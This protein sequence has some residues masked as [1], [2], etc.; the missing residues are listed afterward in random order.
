MALDPTAREAN[1][2]DSIKKHFVDALEPNTTVI[3]D[4]GLATPENVSL[5]KWISIN[6]GQMN[7]STLS[8]GYLQIYVCTRKDNE[9][10]KLAQLR[11][12]VMGHLSDITQTDGM[13]RIDFYRSYQSQP[14]QLIGALLV[15]EVTESPQLDLDDETKYKLL[16]VRLRWGSKI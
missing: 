1:L 7:W 4:K 16:I 14:W 11:D 6:F 12:T 15:Q 2:R 10:F 9:G 3:L 5:E 8:D 13:K